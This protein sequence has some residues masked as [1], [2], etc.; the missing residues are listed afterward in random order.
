MHIKDS[1][2]F[3][4]YI[5]HFDS[6]CRYESV[7]KGRFLVLF[8]FPQVSQY[9]IRLHMDFLGS[10]SPVFDAGS[11]LHPYNFRDKSVVKTFLGKNH[12]KSEFIERQV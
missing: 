3:T 11:H 7:S 2:T 5:I 10:F 4:F 9:A 6:V 12:T 8:S 1:V